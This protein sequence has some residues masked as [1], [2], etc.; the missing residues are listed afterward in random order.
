MH[1]AGGKVKTQLCEALG[2]NRAPLQL[3][4]QIEHKLTAR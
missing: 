4:L 2:V 3:M 1:F